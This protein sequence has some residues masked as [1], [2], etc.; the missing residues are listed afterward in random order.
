MKLYLHWEEVIIMQKNIWPTS[1]NTC[2]TRGK[3]LEKST[4]L[5]TNE[6]NLKLS[7]WHI[8]SCSLMI[9]QMKQKKISNVLTVIGSIFR[10][11]VTRI[12]WWVRYR[13]VLLKLFIYTCHDYIYKHIKEITKDRNFR[14]W[15]LEEREFNFGQKVINAILFSI[16]KTSNN[17]Y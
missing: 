6:H 10:V 1:L 15:Q 7:W 16:R 2:V 17:G 13:N 4:N 9:D 8:C 5:S 11:N 12:V 3:K 14:T